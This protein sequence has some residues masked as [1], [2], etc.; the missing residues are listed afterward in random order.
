[1]FL[2]ECARAA[3]ISATY[4]II[5]TYVRSVHVMYIYTHQHCDGGQ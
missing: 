4:V 1:M 3:A 5:R 2:R